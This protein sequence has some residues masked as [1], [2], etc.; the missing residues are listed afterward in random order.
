MKSIL[1]EEN[2]KNWEK[3]KEFMALYYHAPFSGLLGP[4]FFTSPPPSFV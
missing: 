4:R 3:M 2:R 1:E